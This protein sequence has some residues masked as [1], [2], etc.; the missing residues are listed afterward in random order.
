LQPSHLLE[1][2]GFGRFDGKKWSCRSS[3]MMR[4]HSQNNEGDLDG[5][6]VPREVRPTLTSA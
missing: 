6:E 5:K 3:E 1:C 4:L 2:I